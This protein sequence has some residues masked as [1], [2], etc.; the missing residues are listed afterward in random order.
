MYEAS[1]FEF[2]EEIDTKLTPAWFVDNTHK[3]ELADAVGMNWAADL[4]PYGFG[5]AA[6]K[7]SFPT[8]R[9]IIWRC[10][11]NLRFM[12]SPLVIEDPEEIK[13]RREKFRDVII[14]LADN[15]GP[16]WEKL[17]AEI[18]ER[19]QPFRE[20]D[21]TNATAIQL[22]RMIADIRHLAYRMIEIH[23]WALY[24]SLSFY[25][26]FQ[27]FCREEFGIDGSSK[28]FND[29]L[30]G[31]DSKIL[32][33]ERELWKLANMVR[34]LGLL[35]QFAAPAKEVAPA[36]R[37]TAN[38]DKW[39]A[40]LS[41]FLDEYGFRCELCWVQASPCWRDDLCYAIEKVQHYL[42]R[43][44]F[45]PFD[46]MKQTKENRDIAV[47]KYRKIISPDKRELFELLLKGA[48][49][50]DM[51][52]Q[53]HDF[54]C[55]MHCDAF[56]HMAVLALGK[57]FAQAGTIDD[58]YDVF[59]L[60]IDESRKMAPAPERWHL[61]SLINKRKAK[62]REDLAEGI[63]D[64]ISETMS[65]EEA[66]DWMV[67]SRDPNIIYTLVGELPKAQPELGADIIGMPGA[68]GIAEGPARLVITGEDLD[69]VKTGDILIA[70]TTGISWTTVF[71]LVKGAVLDRGGALSH[72]AIA[73]REYGIPCILN[74]FV[75]T[76]QIK[77]GQRIRID[78]ARGAVYILDKS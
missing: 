55:E 64:V 62:A 50:A 28:D 51:V 15:F 60:Y 21:Y 53:E 1:P 37:G 68:T 59:Y 36:I 25:S 58:P 16:E 4:S 56:L 77:D 40:A 75:G 35:K 38:G 70:P 48:Q 8:C 20:F 42:K 61:Q 27:E 29:M 72:A 30:G 41:D 47:A 19:Y 32:Q 44:D 43:E 23:F 78:G 63:P 39:L 46:Q 73:C 17:K 76:S 33:G 34:E 74:T 7:L 65:K 6:E 45:D 10:Y 22:A 3:P 57:K 13:Q 52:N 14:W 12:I 2:V 69:K 18:M 66:Y 5:W 31:L 71:A 24:G 54:Y 9:G 49:Y 11:K 26:L 67:R